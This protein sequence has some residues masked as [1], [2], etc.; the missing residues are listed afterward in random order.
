MC[1][2]TPIS[3]RK[4]NKKNPF[5]LL[6]TASYHW[7]DEK[8][9]KGPLRPSK[10]ASLFTGVIILLSMVIIEKLMYNFIATYCAGLDPVMEIKRHQQILARHI[11]VDALWCFV[12]AY[13][14]CGNWR[15]LSEVLT[16]KKDDEFSRRIYTYQPS[17]HQILLVFLAYQVK[18]LYDS[19][20][21]NDGIIFILHHIFAGVTALLGMYPGVASMYGIFF[22][23]IS[24]SSTFFLCLLANFD[25]SFG[26]DGL[27]VAFPKTRIF[28]AFLF[29]VSFI[30][31]RIIMWPIC[32]YHFL[33]DSG[34][35]L[36][37]NGDRETK[38]VKLAL[39]MMMISSCLLTILQVVWLGEI[40]LTAKKEIEALL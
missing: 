21:W 30:T 6:S 28:L 8:G 13:V 38:P 20:V 29:I 26:V 32:T 33:R 17:G 9:E 5:F 3:T 16:L 24:E 14:G 1:N 19:Y 18:N 10:S 7:T 11:G 36:K 34:S 23:G 37:I 27:D 31:V 4:T 35:V 15:I 39:A 40:L 2:K 22:M 25:P 12:V